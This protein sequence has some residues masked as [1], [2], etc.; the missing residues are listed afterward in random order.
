MEKRMPKFE[1]EDDKSAPEP[2]R[3]RI[4]DVSEMDHPSAHQLLCH[5]EG[6]LKR[7]VSR[8]IARHLLICAQCSEELEQL[9]AGLSP[10]VNRCSNP[11]GQSATDSIENLH[12][13]PVPLD[14][15]VS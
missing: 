12:N 4:P 13:Q 6:V 9:E 11:V 3:R 15:D 8:T 2:L 14:Y 1:S 10:A 7:E 5:A